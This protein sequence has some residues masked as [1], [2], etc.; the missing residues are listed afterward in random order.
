MLNA[1]IFAGKLLRDIPAAHSSKPIL[2]TCIAT[3]HWS[4]AVLLTKLAS[5]T[6]SAHMQPKLVGILG[7]MGP[8]ATVDL[9]HKVIEFTPASRDQD[10]VPL[11]VWNVPQI[12]ARTEAID[13]DS[14]PSP[15]AA[16]EEGAR[17][18]ATA[19]AATIAIA[20]NTA[21]FWAAEIET[22][23]GLPLLHIA[24]AALDELSERT[25]RSGSRARAVLL[26][27]GGTHRT[28][29]YAHRAVARG[30]LLEVCDEANQAEVE[31]AITWVKRGDVEQAVRV[32]QPVL[33]SLRANGVEIFVLGCTELPLVV[34][35]MY[36]QIQCVDATA[37]LARSIVAFSL[38]SHSEVEHAQVKN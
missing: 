28:G 7:G 31:R 15:I 3:R 35:A 30:M 29:V 19:G 24:D 16:L 14:A 10:H 9:M 4:S 37:A 21:H 18:L 8:A 23:S 6:N 2:R 34:Q 27:T 38:S 25:Q 12:P 32:L 11:V 26:A 5:M 13:S 33:D 1:S 17:A 22:A 36:S 20:C